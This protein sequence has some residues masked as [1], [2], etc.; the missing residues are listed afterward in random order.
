[1]TMTTTMTDRVSGDSTAVL[2]IGFSAVMLYWVALHLVFDKISYNYYEPAVLFPYAGFDWVEPWAGRGLH[3]H[4]V[5]L[6]LACAAMWVG[7]FYRLAS[8]VFAFGFAYVF[9]LD[10]TTYQNHYYLVTLLGFVLA[11]CPAHRALSFDAL[12]LKTDATVPKWSLWLL[13]FQ[14]GVVYFYG[15]I[16]KINWDW[17][18]GFPMRQ[19]LASKD[20]HPVIGSICDQ[21]WLVQVFVWGGLLL[22]LFIVPA[23][24][25]KR[26]RAFAYVAAVLFH[27]ANASLFKIGIFPWAMIVLTTI[28]F[29]PNWPS[30]L[31]P[32]LV[33]KFRAGNA[34]DVT[35]PHTRAGWQT[36][37]L[38]VCLVAFVIIQL[39]LPLRHLAFPENT[40]WTERNHHFAWHMMLRGKMT[41]VRFH[42]IDKETGRGGVYPLHEDL[43]L[44]QVVRMTRDPFMIRQFAKHVARVSREKGFPNVEVRVFALCSLNGRKPQLLIDPEIDLA[45]DQLPDNWIVPLESDVGGNWKMPIERWEEVVMKDPIEAVYKK[46]SKP[47]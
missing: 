45:S 24:L 31:L 26:T 28:F 17:V 1:M 2:R 37:S 18:S 40:N 30:Q 12:R 42:V 33:T 19:V 22:D 4:F 25:W 14:I 5:I 13:R 46:G 23:L 38:K 15:G 10:K 9:L 16:A 44:H 47:D 43:K 32:S 41:A 7:A 11:I 39:V 35:A 29:A 6:L 8:L 27:L 36:T 21:E 34:A 3:L 20:W